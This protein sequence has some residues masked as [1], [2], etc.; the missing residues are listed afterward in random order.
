MSDEIRKR[1]S[2]QLSGSG[3]DIGPLHR[4]MLTHERMKV[5]YVDRLRIEDLKEHYPE[6]AEFTLIPPDILDDAETLVTVPYASQDFVIAA[7]VIEHMKDPIGAIKNWLRVLKPNGLLYLVVPDYRETF[8]KYR[9]LTSLHHII[10]DYT[11]RNS[12]ADWFHY[13]DYAQNV[14][15]KFFKRNLDPLKE[16]RRLKDTDYSIHFHTFTPESFKDVLMYVDEVVQSLHLVDYC[17]TD[18]QEFHYLVR[19]I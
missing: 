15:I 2:D 13:I 19:K 9:R 14:N 12:K 4:P 5:Q 16:A 17:A 11:I 18:G 3:L 1:F 6:L 8:D 7:H 10:A